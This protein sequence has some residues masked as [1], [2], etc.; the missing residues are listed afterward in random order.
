MTHPT[1]KKSPLESI[2]LEILEDIG[3]YLS[4]YHPSTL[5]QLMLASR[6]LYHR[7][8]PILYRE[9][10]VGQITPRFCHYLENRY[11]PTS[12]LARI[13]SLSLGEYFLHPTLNELAYSATGLRHL[14]ID[15][16]HAQDLEIDMFY[17]Y[18]S[19]LPDLETLEVKTCPEYLRDAHRF[20][21]PFNFVGSGLEFDLA[22]VTRPLPRLSTLNISCAHN[23][24]AHM[25][26]QSSLTN[27]ILNLPNFTLPV[28]TALFQLR[29]LRVLR[30]YEPKKILIWELQRGMVPLFKGLVE[31][32]FGGDRSIWPLNERLYLE[33]ATYRSIPK[34]FVETILAHNPQIQKASL[35]YGTDQVLSLFQSAGCLKEL[36][37]AFPFPYFWD[38][39]DG[40]V[41]YTFETLSRF[42]TLQTLTRL[43]LPCSP[44]FINDTANVQ[45]FQL[46]E[47]RQAR[48]RIEPTA[49]VGFFSDIFVSLPGIGLTSK[50]RYVEPRAVLEG[51]VELRQ[52][53]VAVTIVVGEDL[54]S[55]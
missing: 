1:P 38:W 37:V 41:S 26:F 6:S 53:E 28:V 25:E 10:D 48:F 34:G 4:P 24:G 17:H 20:F 54:I 11:I 21:I 55:Y 32:G 12:H 35:L 42:L 27:L 47:S 22:R 18:V 36:V 51:G 52:F 45:I 9:I 46:L 39:I 3:L 19:R 31:F 29:N 5:L 40:N 43:C 14:S 49:E 15:L 13:R 8:L 33:D 50:K 44:K 30:I 16:G 7:I 2:P 23:L